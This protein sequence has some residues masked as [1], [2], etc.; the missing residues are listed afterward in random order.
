M[1]LD[2]K[3]PRAWGAMGALF[4]VFGVIFS[5]L[6]PDSGFGLFLMVIGLLFVVVGLGLLIVRPNGRGER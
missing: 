1:E 2:Q 5:A 4:L 3:D 6:A